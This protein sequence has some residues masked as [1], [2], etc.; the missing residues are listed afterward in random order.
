MKNLNKMASVTVNTGMDELNALKTK[1]IETIISSVEIKTGV[2]DSAGSILSHAESIKK[3]GMKWNVRLGLLPLYKEILA[4]TGADNRQ[5]VRK[6]ER[7][8]FENINKLM[9]VLK[10]CSPEYVQIDTDI[11]S[12]IG[13]QIGSEEQA[14]MI[15]SCINGVK[16]VLPECK[17]ILGTKESTDNEKA[18]KWFNRFQVSGGKAFDIISLSYELSADTFYDL[19]LNM[20]DLSRRFEADI[21]VD[22][23]LQNNV[24]AADISLEDLDNAVSIVPLERGYG[25]VYSKNILDIATQVA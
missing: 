22:I 4:E 7:A 17:V 8:A 10:D 21:I 5:F 12:E 3:L 15:N 23:S 14:R 2:A 9:N 13:I 11:Y 24:E 16:S 1:G 18:K 20:S 6:S 25:T 19:S